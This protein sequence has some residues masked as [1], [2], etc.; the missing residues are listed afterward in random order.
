MFYLFYHIYLR[1]RM[2]EELFCE[3]VFPVVGF[4]YAWFLE[5]VKF[6]SGGEN[7]EA[8]DHKGWIVNVFAGQ[9][10]FGQD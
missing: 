3:N 2:F 10:R 4:P 9:K 1:I 5:C 7:G 8:L 6:L